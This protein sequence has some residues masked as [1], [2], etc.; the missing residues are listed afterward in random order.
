MPGD[1]RALGKCVINS[2]REFPGREVDVHAGQ[3]VQLDPLRIARNRMVMDFIDDDRGV[4]GDG[5]M[6]KS[7]E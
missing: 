4:V 1:F 2:T 3:A 5:R 7:R 6:E